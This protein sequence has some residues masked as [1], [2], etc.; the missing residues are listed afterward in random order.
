MYSHTVFQTCKSLDIR[1][2]VIWALNLVIA[3]GHFFII[4]FQNNMSPVS[5]CCISLVDE[6]KTKTPQQVVTVPPIPIRTPLMYG[7]EAVILYKW[8]HTLV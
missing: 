5:R 1:P 8:Q 4:D 7:I 3:D 6:K 2:S